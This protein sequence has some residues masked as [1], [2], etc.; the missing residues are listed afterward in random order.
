MNKMIIPLLLIA[1]VTTSICASK[2]DDTLKNY[3][4]N[5]KLIEDGMKKNI[6][7][8][9][10]KDQFKIFPSFSPKYGQI[11]PVPES[12]FRLQQEKNKL[13]LI[14]TILWNMLI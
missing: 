12:F 2:K 3:Q 6:S 8:N 9:S 4:S 13:I 11:T 7:G 10:Q 5:L 14:K 1:M